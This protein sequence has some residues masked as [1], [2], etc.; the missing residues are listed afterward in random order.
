LFV[1]PPTDVYIRSFQHPD[2]ETFLRRL[3]TGGLI[4]EIFD[5]NEGN[6]AMRKGIPLNE[7]LVTSDRSTRDAMRAAT[8]ALI[9]DVHSA[10]ICHRDLHSGNIVILDDR[11][12]AIDFGLATEVEAAWPCYDISGPS[13]WVPVPHAHAVQGGVIGTTGVWWDAAKD[14]NWPSD[15]YY[16]PLGTIFGPPG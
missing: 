3:S 16:G 15:P 11:P 7:W 10:G 5:W 1:V 14:P 6:V 12:L 8:L 9:H 4:P 2:E 13:K